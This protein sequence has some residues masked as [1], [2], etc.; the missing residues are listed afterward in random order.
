MFSSKT[1]KPRKYLPWAKCPSTNECAD[2]LSA[3]N[4]DI[5]RPQSRH[6]VPSTERIGRDIRAQR[7]ENKRKRREE[8]GCAVVPVI[9]EPEWVPDNLSVKGDPR[10]SHGNSDKAG[11]CECNRDN[12]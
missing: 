8:S 4:I 3:P 11:Q 1:Y 9:D 2:D 5:A 6:V 7:T 12:N 10:T